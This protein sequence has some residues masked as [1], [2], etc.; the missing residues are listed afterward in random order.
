MTQKNLFI[1]TAAAICIL[2]A[3][4]SGCSNRKKSIEELY[5]SAVID[6]MF[7]EPSEIHPLVCITEDEPLVTW[8]D[9]K[10]LMLTL[11][12]YPDFYTE[13]KDVTFTFGHSWTFTDREMEEWYKKNGQNV[14]N[15]SFRL[16]QLLGITPEQNHT[17]I[18]AFWTDP[19]DIRRPAYQPD[20]S[21]QLTKETLDGSALD[22]LSN[23]FCSNIVSSYYIG[24]TKYPWT[25]LGYTY[26]WA[27]NGTDYGVTEFLVLKNSTVTVEFTKSVPEFVD[28]L[29]EQTSR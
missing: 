12:K 11:H 25:R 28:W 23:W 2:A 27:D 20:A 6:A 14:T 21:K 17:H 1:R 10:V 15:W 16:K 3:V 9:G 19:K 24:K 7:A 26:D 8:K 18:S 22:E 29:E 13:G 4:F 5:E